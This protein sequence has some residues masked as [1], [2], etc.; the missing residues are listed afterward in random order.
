LEKFAVQLI[1]EDSLYLTEIVVTLRPEAY[2]I[3]YLPLL[4]DRLTYINEQKQIAFIL[5]KVLHYQQDIMLGDDLP[6]SLVQDL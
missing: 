6:N 1:R 3:Q 4:S 2:Q 5:T